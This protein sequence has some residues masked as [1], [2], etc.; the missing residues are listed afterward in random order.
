MIASAEGFIQEL[1]QPSRS[2][3][4]CPYSPLGSK[5]ASA[6]PFAGSFTPA[7]AG[8]CAA[9]SSIGFAA[10]HT[11]RTA[12][13]ITKDHYGGAAACNAPK[14]IDYEAWAPEG[15]AWDEHTK[16]GIQEFLEDAFGN[17]MN[18]AQVDATLRALDHASSRTTQAMHGHGQHAAERTGE[19]PQY[20][21]G[22]NS[23]AQIELANR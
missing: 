7:P 23:E 15:W 4:L 5:G 14:E 10:V 19:A 22:R 16:A 17:H 9:E 12:L 20:E 13:A 8:V 1:S 11:Y 2:G 21:L 3:S 6:M 18:Q